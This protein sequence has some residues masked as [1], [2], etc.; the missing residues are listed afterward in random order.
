VKIQTVSRQPQRGARPTPLLFVHGAWH[1]AWCWQEHFLDYFAERGYA[2]HALD[3]R[4]HGA[5]EGR[6]QLW[7]TRI[8]D[9]VADVVKVAERLPAPPV[10]IGH[11]MGGMVVQKYL[12]R[13]Q[14]PAAV[15][16]ASVPHYGAAGAAAYILRHH[17][18]AFLKANLTLSLY[19]LVATPAQV[20][21]SF[22][23]ARLP[24]ADV[25]R[26]ATQLQDESYV[27][28]LDMLALALPRPQR[29]KSPLLVLG[30]D[31]DALFPPAAVQATAR[32]YGTQAE[33]FTG[34][35]HNLM[36]DVGWENVAGR[37]AGWLDERGL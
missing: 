16:L 7:R 35:A 8:A 13:Q 32:A 1:G 18:L 11:S 9:Y 26:Y 25:E 3:L 28:F 23:S 14:A 31:D 34:M 22:Y 27:G 29:V 19:P 10:V 20:R 4:G 12:E 6:A 2:A 5:S 17:P 33:I 21:E 30:G 36:L 15:L 24:Q 37:I